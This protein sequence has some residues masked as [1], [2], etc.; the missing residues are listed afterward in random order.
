MTATDL[1]QLQETQRAGPTHDCQGSLLLTAAAVRSS[2]TLPVRFSQ[3]SL[4]RGA[5]RPHVAA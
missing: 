2:L 5:S 4:G 3:R 1:S